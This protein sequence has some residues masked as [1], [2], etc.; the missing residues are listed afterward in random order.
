MAF[1]YKPSVRTHFI[2][3]FE[4]SQ[5]LPKLSAKV[6]A[7]ESNW[8]A[9]VNLGNSYY[10]LGETEKALEW[11]KK[12]YELN[13]EDAV[14]CSNLGIA[15]A[16]HVRWEEAFY[17][18]EKANRLDPTDRYA[19]SVYAEFLLGMGQWKMGWD[20]YERCRFSIPRCPLPKYTGGSLQGAK[21]LV[22][23]EGGAGDVFMAL[24]FFK[25]LRELKPEKITFSV[26][27]GLH[28]LLEAHPWLD[29][30]LGADDVKI[31]LADYDCWVSSFSL[32]SIFVE[33]VAEIPWP[34]PY[35]HGELAVQRIIGAPLK[36]GLCWRAGEQDE[37]RRHRVLSQE[38][39]EKLI[40]VEGV[41]WYGLQYGEKREGLRPLNLSTWETTAEEID[42][43]DLVVSVDTGV[44]HL[45]GSIGKPVWTLLSNSCWRFLRSG[46][47]CIWY[48]SMRLFRNDDR[49]YDLAVSRVVE[50]LQKAVAYYA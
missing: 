18:V 24:R 39:I 26:D 3:A 23:Q 19:A 35:L 46:D 45:A 42:A 34:G 27:S 5:L 43:L 50:E 10:T 13:P 32:A 44:M 12:A 47:S 1:G 16:D 8:S 7:D 38:N 33:S 9:M 14:V 4:A 6:Q 36:V 49:G 31:N 29:N 37:N 30:L 17:Y 2:N 48:P 11:F 28:G 22:L 21:V 15:L 20:L 40:A 41:R 25:N